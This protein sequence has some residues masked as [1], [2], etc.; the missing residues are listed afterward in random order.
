MGRLDGKNVFI[1]GGSR[2]IGFA[3]AREALKE[4]ANAIAICSHYVE[5]REA[6]LAKLREEFPGRNIEGYTP[7][8]SSEE[9]IGA[10]MHD[11][12]GKYDNHLDAVCHIAG[13][14]HNNSIKNIPDGLFREVIEVNLIGTYNVD[15]Q[16]GLIMRQ[17]R[18]GSIVNT[19]SITGVYGCNL[20]CAY[21]ASKAGVLGLTRS[22]ARELAYFKIRVNAVCPGV[23]KTDM[24]MKDTSEAAMKYVNST[25]ALGRMGEPEELAKMFVFLASDDSSY[26]TGGYYH[27]DGWTTA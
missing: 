12:I 1:T 5:T 2:G 22:L 6:A 10:A 13:I 17:Q 15:R 8:L 7:N 27:A 11:F 16:A 20:G 19:S 9:E 3:T 21:G 24:S 18:Y 14:T 23:V 4:G 26:C 25:I